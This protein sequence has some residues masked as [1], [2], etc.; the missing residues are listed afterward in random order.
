[1][2]GWFSLGTAA[3]S[4]NS[5]TGSDGWTF[6]AQDKSFDYLAE[7]QS[8]TLSYTVQVDDGHGGVVTQPV[9]ITI[10]GTNDTP[11]IATTSGAFAELSTTNNA[12]IDHADGS[13]SFADVDL[14]DR[15]SVSA[16]YAS[17]AYENAEHI[18]IT[19]TLTAQQLA[20]IA[21]VEAS[22]TLT[23]SSSNSNNG[24]VAWSYD[25]PDNKFDFLAAGDT[26]MLTYTATVD[27]THGGITTKPVTISITG[28]NDTPTILAETNAPTQAVIVLSPVT[29][30]IL[31][32]GVNTNSLG[33][34]TETFDSLSAGSASNNGAGHGSF[35][36]A[37]L[38]ATFSAS[39]NAGVVIGSSAVS[40]APF[41][42]P[43]PGA[44]DDTN[45]LSIGAGGTETITFDDEKNAFGLYWGSLDSFNTIKFYDDATLVA[46]Y[47]GA[48]IS[49]L[50]PTGNQSMFSA[51]GYVEFSN[52]ANFNKV[53][54]GTGDSNAFEI[55]NISAG[56]VAD[57][58]VELS[59][60][61]SGS[62]TVS[63]ADIGDTLTASVVGDAHLEYNGSTTLPNNADVSA[64]IAANAITF[65]TVTSNGGVEVL[66][67]T[68]DPTNPDLDFLKS[69]DTLTITFTAQVNDGQVSVGNQ[70][71]TITLTGTETPKTS[72]FEVV[73]GTS[74]NDMFVNV[75]GNTTIFGADGQDTFVFNAGFGSATIGDFDVNKDTIGIDHTLVA[76]ISAL[77]ASAQAI[78]SGHDT[79]L[80]DAFHDTITLAGVTVA[81]IQ[82][83]QAA[84]HLV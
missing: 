50:L 47:T 52:L 27:D 82:A 39:G 61:I 21:D 53:V 32:H 36:S 70:P 49:P 30:T 17:F 55:D 42:G 74:G 19:A 69:G 4:T 51:S 44:Q 1:V 76:D 10:T 41:I 11:A 23:P 57:S 43:L 37:T 14:T 35:D 60:P 6:S 66:H 45:Y 13:I 72:D 75:G 7:G 9:A 28:T 20:A 78:N 62:L 3:E 26:L 80:T 34:D 25:V 73:N 84:F 40:A 15:P 16:H 67:W 68:Y 33:L 59:A 29:P 71:L 5:A 63:D 38:Q 31:A 8:V 56:S 81:Q 79:I 2:L 12:S 83:H 22:L 18:N 54:L 48:D 58:H 77:L 24:S 46:S 65:D 64:L